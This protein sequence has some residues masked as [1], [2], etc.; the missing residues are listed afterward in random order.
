MKIADGFLLKT[1]AGKNIVVSV[2]AEVNF[3]GMLTLND[4]GVYLWNLL[5]K[6]T[7]KD[8]ILNK[9]LEEYDVSEEIASADIDAFIQ[10]LR[11][12]NILED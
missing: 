3:N 5:Q 11:Q 8:D 4:T 12:A 7:T 9:M 10:K 1:V 2:G 6:D